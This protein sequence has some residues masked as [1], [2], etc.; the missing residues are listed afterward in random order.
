MSVVLEKVNQETE[1]PALDESVEKEPIEK[2]TAQEEQEITATEEPPKET[3][4]PKKRGRPP[5]A[6]AAPPEKPL[7][8]TKPKATPRPKVRKPKTPPPHDSSSDEEEVL[9]NVYNHVSKPDM[10]TAILQ[11]LVNR[12][13][14][15]ASRRRELWS[16][17]AR[18]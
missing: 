7:E 3:P 18:M 6:K 12:R 4:Q 11:F 16:S 9:Q 5:K 15:E 14:N 10:E 17:L 1:A 13:Q 8:A 2:E